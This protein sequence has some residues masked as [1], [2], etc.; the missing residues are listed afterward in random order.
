[1]QRCTQSIDQFPKHW[2]TY[3]G[4]YTLKLA[5]CTF[6]VDEVRHCLLL[7]LAFIPGL[8]D[9]VMK[10]DL[11]ITVECLDSFNYT[12][13]QLS[14][15]HY[16]YFHLLTAN[17]LCLYFFTCWWLQTS[18]GVI[19]MCIHYCYTLC[20]DIFTRGIISPFLPR[21]WQHCE[22]TLDRYSI[23]LDSLRPP[24]DPKLSD[25]QRSPFFVVRL[26]TR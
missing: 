5:T 17:T 19:D 21:D 14:N 8:L 23:A 9:I 20:Y 24:R 1:M 4:Y 16:N 18:V 12:W 3:W 13:F 10:C 6:N 26:E 25:E 11:V 7:V 22:R 2:Y 15:I